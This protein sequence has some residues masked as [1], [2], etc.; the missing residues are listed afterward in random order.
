M[1]TESMHGEILQWTAGTGVNDN[2]VVIQT[3]DTSRYDE[4]MLQSTAGAMD[5]FVSLDG[6]NYSTAALSIL[7]LGATTSDPVVVTAAN[8]TYAFFGTFR[9]IRVLQNG[10]T[11]VANGT[12]L[13][14]R[15]T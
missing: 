10:A 12:L 3:N 11:G 15:H 8:R 6:T 4:F 1:A 13:G 7:D 5:V 2:D 14:K 9:K